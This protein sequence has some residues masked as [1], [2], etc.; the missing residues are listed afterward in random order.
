MDRIITHVAMECQRNFAELDFCRTSRG[1]LL[2]ASKFVAAWKL[3]TRYRKTTVR[4]LGE[5]PWTC[6]ENAFHYSYDGVKWSQIGP[7][8]PVLNFVLTG[9]TSFH[10]TCG[11]VPVFTPDGGNRLGTG[12]DGRSAT[13]G[14]G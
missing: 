3:Q 4:G 12:P 13:S 7:L 8:G 6:P 9:G 10:K 11:R 5:A 14:R 1:N 2:L